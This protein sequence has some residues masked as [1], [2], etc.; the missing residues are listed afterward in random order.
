MGWI[1]DD[2]QRA[3]LIG[4]T[5]PGE[6]P[7]PCPTMLIGEFPG[8]A[9]GQRGRP[10]IGK[11]GRELTRYLN[12]YELPDRT[13]LYLTNLSKTVAIDAKTSD[14]TPADLAILTAEIAACQPTTIVT[15]GARV[16]QFFLG[17][18]VALEA[19]HSIPH[20]IVDWA[21]NTAL[22][23]IACTPTI[24]PSY[25]PA[26]MLH[27]PNLQAV[28]AYS[29]RRLSAHLKG[30]LPAAAVDAREGLYRL[31]GTTSLPP[32]TPTL[33]ID[34]EGWRHRAWCLSAS[35]APYIGDVVRHG[36]HHAYVAGILAERPRIILHNSLHDLGVLADDFGLDLDAERLPY[37]DT[38]IAAYLLGLEPQGL[39]ALA[40]RH[41]GMSMQEYAELTA[42][43]EAALTF[44][45]L[46]ALYDRLPQAARK[47]KKAE[48]VAAGLWP[49]ERIKGLTYV[50]V[51]DRCLTPDDTDRAHA[52]TLVGRML[53]KSGTGLRKRWLDSRAREILV[54]DTDT[55]AEDEADPPEPTLD[56]VPLTDAVTYAARD[57]DA[58]GRIAPYLLAQIDALQLRDVYETDLATVPMFA[59][60]QTVGIGVDVAHFEALE[61]MLVAEAALNR[62]ALAECC[63]HPLNPN[64]AKQVAAW[65][66]DTLR[67]QD[68]SENVR[69]KKT[70][71]GDLSTNDKTLEALE[72]YHPSVG[73]IQDGR[74]IRKLLGSYVRPIPRLVSRADGR[75]HPNYRIT[76]ADTGRPTANR[77][78]VL[79]LPKHSTRGKL[80]RMGLVASEGRELGDWDLSQIEMCVFAHDSEDAQM[81]A[82]ICSGIDKHAATAANIFGRP[83]DVIYGEYKS[84]TGEGGDQRFAAKAVNFGILMGI[85][86]YGLLDQFHKN[87]QLHYTLDDCEALLREWF[88]LYPAAKT[89][90]EAKHAEARRYGYVRDMWGRVRW[91]EGIHSFD[92]YI[93]QEA[94]RQ[95]QATPTQSGAQGIMKRVMRAVW[96][97][98][99]ALRGS[100]WIEPLLQ[101]Y[102]ALVL[103]Y[104]AEQ[105]ALVDAVMRTAMTTTVTLRVPIKCEAGFGTRL[106]E[107]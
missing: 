103:E 102:D 72:S 9:E 20:P 32:L 67:L 70:S 65:L 85:T 21:G 7:T 28:F 83:A 89:Y 3:A 58:T 25:N 76:R 12:G 104:D 48:A 42:D 52:R 91:L 41:A 27:S 96:P 53:E 49:A 56:L 43:A 100:F 68:A 62:E 75:L 82:E 29:M 15:L 11:S 26:A 47:L 73:L 86:A 60:M 98:L 22:L 84:K 66:Y 63:G 97:V 36:G 99:V 39:K 8:I 64:S 54:D 33:A 101:V 13:A 18:D 57:A 24:F 1:L 38:M 17:P 19:V 95:A 87:G 92:D 46:T 105:R 23:D 78:N 77:P 2:E 55:L 34:T 16:T 31:C 5:V 44:T 88:K 107:L 30:R 37:D 94:E 35:G 40:Y 10:F 4:T 69:I 71:G 74:E 50:P 6:G 79:A 81:I 80:V 51:V 106:G 59:R 14:V 90:I 45:W 61:S 93:R